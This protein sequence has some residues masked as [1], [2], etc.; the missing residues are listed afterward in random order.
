MWKL[1]DFAEGKTQ[2]ENAK[3]IKQKLEGLQIEIDV[4]KKLE[5]GI[6]METSQYSNFDIVLE[7][8]FDS[9][10]E[11]EIYQRNSLHIEV[12]DWIGRVRETRTAVDFEI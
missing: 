2:N 6:N 7:T 8:Y 12:S 3:I 5:V 4:I 9:Y 11:M 1:K 10:Q